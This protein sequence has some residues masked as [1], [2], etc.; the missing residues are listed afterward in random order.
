MSLCRGDARLV[1]LRRRI[2]Q[3]D[4]Q[5]SEPRVERLGQPPGVA[6]GELMKQHGDLFH[7]KFWREMQAAIRAGELPEVLPYAPER[8]LVPEY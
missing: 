3:L 1:A 6:G 4:G 7:P 8:R 5:P 2:G